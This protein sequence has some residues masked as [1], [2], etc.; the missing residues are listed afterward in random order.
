[1]WLLLLVTWRSVHWQSRILKSKIVCS[2]S[3]RN[4]SLVARVICRR[5]YVCL[6]LEVRVVLCTPWESNRLKKV[7]FNA[8]T[9][10]PIVQSGHGLQFSA[11]WWKTKQELAWSTPG[12]KLEAKHD[13]KTKGDANDR[14]AFL[15]FIFVAKYEQITKARNKNQWCMVDCTLEVWKSYTQWLGGPLFQSRRCSI[16]SL[17]LLHLSLHWDDNSECISSAFE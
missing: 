16:C 2:G 7:V 4:L 11:M 3:L 13:S 14:K 1:M 10:V 17:R 5:V 8:R 15:V 6:L 12:Y 9:R